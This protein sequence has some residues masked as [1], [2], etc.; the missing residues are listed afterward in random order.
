[1]PDYNARQMDELLAWPQQPGQSILTIAD[2][3]Y[4]Q[5]LKEIYHPPPLLFVKGNLAVLHE[6]QIAIVGCRKMSAYGA[7][8]AFQ[9]AK[10]L[11][12]TGLTITSGLA[13]GIDTLAHQGA[14]AAKGSTIAVLG[15]GLQHIY[16]AQNQQL[17]EAICQNGALISEFP[18][19]APPHPYHF[20]K[21]N[22]II[23]ALSM[24]VLVVEAAEKSGSLITARFALEQNRE[25]FVIPGSIHS[26][27][28]KG[29]HKLIK[30]GATL[31][32]SIP[33]LLIH[34]K[35]KLQVFLAADSNKS[36]KKQKAF[37]QELSI[38]NNTPLQTPTKHVN[39]IKKNEHPLLQFFSEEE[40][41]PIDVLVAKT[42]TSLENLNAD[43]LLL[44]L[45]GDIKMVA[46]GYI[47]T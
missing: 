14:L 3:H 28:S 1:M 20:P 29:C 22:R 44:E 13:M 26:P 9:F 8:N 32:E 47:R 43:L 24:G 30:E 4:P 34:I 25:I 46:G 38:K 10:A 23:S 40:A 18:L 27:V 45:S 39:P 12:E 21:R 19:H 2:M 41:T 7:E 16:P 11:A 35:E 6:P 37:S 33:D 15:T 5:K 36:L 31:V 17:A 42:N